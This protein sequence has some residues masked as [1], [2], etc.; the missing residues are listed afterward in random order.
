M[1]TSLSSLAQAIGNEMV[2]E[3]AALLALKQAQDFE[4][5][6]EVEAV[7]ALLPEKG[8][9]VGLHT[10]LAR[11][12]VACNQVEEADQIR[13]GVAERLNQAEF[14]SA[15]VWVVTPLM[16]RHPLQ[17]VPL[18]AR[19]RDRGGSRAVPHE[20]LETAH[21]V[22][23]GHGFLSWQTAESHFERGNETEALGIA[24]TALPI[25]VADRSYDVAEMALLLLSE[26]V[27]RNTLRAVHR[28]LELLAEQEAWE[29]F[30]N[31]IELVSAHLT[32]PEHARKSWP[33]IREVWRKH[34]D[35]KGLRDAA[36]TVG[37][38]YL[39]QYPDPRTMIRTAEIERPDLA[40]EKILD[41]LRL[42][43][44]FPPGY[45]A[46]HSSWGIGK[47]RENDLLQLILD[48]P[49]K[50]M[51]RMAMATAEHALDTLAPGHLAVLLA[52]EPKQIIE[53]LKT[54]PAAIVV[55]ALESLKD[56]RGTLEAIRKILVPAV[57]PSPSW[58][59]WWKNT[60]KSIA[61]DPR[62]DTR[63]AYKNMFA[64]GSGDTADDVDLPEWD[65]GLGTLKNL[66]LLDVF[67]TQYPDSRA[68]VE[69]AFRTR[70]QEIVDN[71]ETPVVDAVAGD[72][73]LVRMDPEHP[74]SL[75]K[76]VRPGFDMNS[77]P[78]SA[79]EQLLNHLQT[80]EGLLVGL[81][82]RLAGIRK[83]AWERLKDTD[84]VTEAADTVFLHPLDLPEAVLYLHDTL[85]DETRRSG[86]S[87]LLALLDLLEAPPRE[88]HRKRALALLSQDSW[89]A[90]SLRLAPLDS[91]D[92]ERVATRL[93][94]WESSD[95]FR[96]PVMDFLREAGHASIS[97]SV[98]GARVREAARVSER[99]EAEPK[100]PSVEG[101]LLTRPTWERLAAE[102]TQVGME[103]KTTIP[104]AIQKAR[105][106]GDLRENAEY[107]AAKA[108]QAN[109][110]KRFEELE[111]LMNG[112]RLIEDLPRKEGTALPGTK[113]M[114]EG[115]E[116]KNEQLEFWLLGE[117][118]QELGEH[119]VSYRAAVGKALLGRPVGDV[120]QLPRGE[121]SVSY[122]ITT[123]EEKLP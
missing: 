11:S 39:E 44:K 24:A 64:L 19:A 6:P 61:T 5:V 84:S 36:I 70:V 17:S 116:N 108:K 75:E 14:W 111:R 12:L 94:H 54:D 112:A 35:H 71:P 87:R 69:E 76:R 104:L 25:L 52:H 67:L 18:I 95:R 110:A 4:P 99:M 26:S 98:E 10:V 72:L 43:E 89:I 122:R 53:L 30:M 40:V 31:A 15:L 97:D 78:K 93:N 2:S 86:A 21:R 42:L 23:P 102:R 20:L 13:F 105:E 50:P 22:L 16:E 51:H 34:P 56:G 96:F 79:Q 121:K 59:S 38:A 92:A 41:R 47:I 7:R 120:V 29:P 123:V 27:D 28:S 33:V 9:T 74:V 107:D 73:W 65:P 55:K 68:R 45:Y 37:R 119:V 62:V 3:E 1:T 101:V 83:Q 85:D 49:S 90:R 113:V 48:F 82:S 115:I 118:D 60:Q 106:L 91:E 66:N 57:M 46:R 8:V 32:S 117:G 58:V 103:L 63:E 80:T 100:D 88:T 109:Y 81:N 114:L 77:L